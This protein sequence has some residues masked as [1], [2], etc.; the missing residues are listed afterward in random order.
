MPTADTPLVVHVGYPKTATTTF[1]QDVFP[2]HP[3]IDYLGKHIPSFRYRH[4]D[5]Y[6]QIDALL[7]SN[8]LHRPDLTPLRR[9]VE[10]V[11]RE[12]RRKVVLL[13]SESF[14]HPMAIDPAVVAER[15]HEAFAPCRIWITI[16]EQL[17]LLLSFYWMHGRFG[18]YLSL[19]GLYEGE[20]LEM[21]FSFPRW[22]ELQRRAP[23]RNLI[24]LLRYDEVIGQYR[25]LFGPDQVHVLAYERLVDE[26]EAFS[27]DVSG[28]LGVDPAVTRRLGEGKWRNTASGRRAPWASADAAQ[29]VARNGM[30]GVFDRFRNDRQQRDAMAAVIA[31]LGDDY[32][33]AN[34]RTIEMTGLPLGALG[35][36]V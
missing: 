15:V 35:Y 10:Q 25:K 14:I 27:D 31:S 24:G 22:I 34:Q 2:A 36:A 11:R 5:T 18:Q 32:R 19:A 21:P 7:C 17:A 13:S 6:H 1:Q 20:R 16:R 28:L 9:Y 23:D 4:E 29:V 26:P 3:E 12:S 8:G 33:P 30:A